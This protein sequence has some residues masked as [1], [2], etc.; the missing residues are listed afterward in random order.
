MT[1]RV[2]LEAERVVDEADLPGLQGRIAVAAL[3]LT[4][5]AMARDRLASIMWAEPPEGWERSLSPI[6]SKVRRALEKAGDDGSRLVSSAGSVEMRRDPSIWV[7]ALDA[8]RELDAAEGALRRDDA[9]RAW[10]GAAVASAVFRRPF[11]PG[12]SGLWID[13]QRRAFHNR[14]VRAFEVVADA[15]SLLDDPVQSGAAAEQLIA[16]DPYRETGYIKLMRACAD[17]GNRA[18]ALR[19]F[20]RARE[21]LASELGVEPSD[22]LQA[23]Y[24]EIL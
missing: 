9:R 17:Q 24:E 12:V 8:T 16:I 10:V 18:A 1:G 19:V 3:A 14:L 6:L 23:V 2:T 7:D 13:E 5:H 20:A 15:W 22:R 4:P 11:L 21:V